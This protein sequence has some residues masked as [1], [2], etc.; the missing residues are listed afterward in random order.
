MRY[1][2]H[3]L[4]CLSDSKFVFLCVIRVSIE[5]CPALMFQVKSVSSWEMHKTDLF[6]TPHWAKLIVRLVK[7]LRGTSIVSITQLSNLS[8][9]SSSAA[10]STARSSS[11]GRKLHLNLWP[12]GVLIASSRPESSVSL[13]VPSDITSCRASV[14]T[15]DVCWHIVWQLSLWLFFRSV[16]VFFSMD[17]RTLYLLSETGSSGGLS[18]STSVLVRLPR[19][20]MARDRRL[21]FVLSLALAAGGWGERDEGREGVSG[22]T[23]EVWAIM[24]LLRPLEDLGLVTCILSPEDIEF[25]SD[26]QI[27]R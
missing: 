17:G 4:K 21:W 15:C 22:S 10:D 2:T 1:V 7:V 9:N 20:R 12:H 27:D 11:V 23:L 3:N 24:G 19:L 14:W 8:L 16:A 6:R 25:W 26:R 5:S 18:A 13:P